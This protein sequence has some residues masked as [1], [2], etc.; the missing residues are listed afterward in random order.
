MLFLRKL[1]G[2]LCS[3]GFLSQRDKFGFA[4]SHIESNEY[5]DMF[6]YIL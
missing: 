4:N 2:S 5:G 3:M 6:L 1:K